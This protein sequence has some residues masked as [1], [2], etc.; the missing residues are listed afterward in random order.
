MK[1]LVIV[2]DGCAD[3][4]IPSL[5]GKTPLE[6]ADIKHIDG[7]A[8]RGEVGMVRTIPEGIEPGSD[9]ANL[10]IMGYDPAVYLTGRASLEAA[11]L[12]ID[13]SPMD[14]A[15]RVN[16]ITV[17]GSGNYEDLL[18]KDHSAGEISSE[19]AETLIEV[20]D[21][22]LGSEEVAFYPGV[23]YRCLLVTANFSAHTQLTPPHDVLGQKVGPNM[24]KGEGAEPLRVLLSRSYEILK[25]HPVNR[26]RVKRGLNPAN[27]I[28]LWGQGTKPRLPL[29]ADKYGL[30]GSVIS[31]VNL[32]KGIGVCAGLSSV[33]VPGADG[34]LQTNYEGKALAAIDEFRKGREFVYIHVEAPDE[35]AH[36]GDLQG[37]VKSLELIDEKIV[38]SVTAYLAGLG[39]PYRILVV[40]DHRTPMEIRTHSAE[41]V[42]F[43]LFDSENVRPVEGGRV[44]TELSGEGGSYRMAS[45]CALANTFF[46]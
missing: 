25:A 20:I 8:G 28:W 21:R 43:V 7:L 37:K 29:F 46:R 23:S 30:T 24:P 18:I 33:N 31:G 26:Q 6:V 45:G 9:A 16:F 41:P 27:S 14:V 2:P 35:C 13:L 10:S 22:Q 42:P 19:E 40:P 32:I 36:N 11:G 34:T 3:R 5:G 44:F 12:G 17:E 1:Y 15:F 38:K 4:P 39:E